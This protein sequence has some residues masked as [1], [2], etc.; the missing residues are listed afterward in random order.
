MPSRAGG[1][2]LHLNALIEV[3]KRAGWNDSRCN[4]GD[5]IAEFNALMLPK[6]YVHVDESGLVHLV[7]IGNRLAKHGVSDNRVRWSFSLP[8]AALYTA[9]VVWQFEPLTGLWDVLK[10]RTGVFQP[11]CPIKCGGCPAKTP[12]LE[13]SATRA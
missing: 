10:D 13:G 3:I 2:V 4:V 7:L 8:A 5:L 6:G 9:D 12:V 11:L 1:K